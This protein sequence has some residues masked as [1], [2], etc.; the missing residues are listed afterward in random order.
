MIPSPALFVNEKTQTAEN[1]S[2]KI[3]RITI[4]VPSSGSCGPTCLAAARS[5]RGSDMPPACHS[6]PRRRFASLQGE[7]LYA[8]GFNIPLSIFHFQFSIEKKPAGAGF[9]LSI[10][11]SFRIRYRG[12]RLRRVSGNRPT[13]GLRREGFP[14]CC[15]TSC[16][17]RCK[18]EGPADRRGLRYQL[19]SHP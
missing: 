13:W 12:N 3:I 5:R 18:P 10:F 1:V 16:F 4:R 8:A 7:G 17:P 2:K 11:R 15:R 9:F 19:R 14:K 6:L